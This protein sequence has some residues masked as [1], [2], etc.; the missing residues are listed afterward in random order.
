[1]SPGLS[2]KTPWVG[3]PAGPERSRRAARLHSAIIAWLGHPKRSLGSGSGENR[4]G[5]AFQPDNAVY[6][7]HRVGMS[8]IIPWLG[9]PKKTRGS[10][11]PQVLSEAEGQP[12]SILLSSLGWGTPRDR[13]G[14]A[15]EK[16]RVGQ[17]FQPDNA[18][19]L[20]HRV[21]MS[22]IIPWLGLPKKPRG[23]GILPDSLAFR[24]GRAEQRTVVSCAGRPA[25]AER[26]QGNVSTP[27]QPT[28]TA[29]PAL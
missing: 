12:D 14:Q 25:H 15:S 28:T 19:Y 16:N 29:G 13:L 6:L 18:V 10:G 27:K 2:Q 8:H 24:R 9:L 3:H 20:L 21:G 5:Q 17:A 7:L 26:Y 4:V 11:I 23:S 22:H 1:M